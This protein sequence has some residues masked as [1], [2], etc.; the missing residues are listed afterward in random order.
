MSNKVVQAERVWYFS[1]VSSVKVEGVR[2]SLVPRPPPFF[3]LW[4]AFS[5]IHS[6]RR[7]SKN[8]EVPVSFITWMTS[9]GR[10]V[11]HRENGPIIKHVM[12]KVSFLPV[13]TSSFAR[14]AVECLNGW[15][16]VLFCGWASPPY[17]QPRIHFTSTW[18]HSRDEWDQASPV[19]A[20]SS[21]SMYYNKRKSNSKKRRRPG[22]EASVKDVNCAW[23]YLKTQNSRKS[24]TV[25]DWPHVSS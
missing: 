18:C 20:V 17:I 16:S 1:H 22:N 4:F 10:K 7:H 9:V 12:Q 21:T 8:R 19:F 3:V 5:I 11:G 6:S 23:V 2:N 24:E 15:S 13:K 14:T 25:D